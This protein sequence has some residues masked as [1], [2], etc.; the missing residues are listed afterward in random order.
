MGSVLQETIVCWKD[1]LP[2][3][4]CLY[5]FFY[6]FLSLN[7]LSPL[8]WPRRDVHRG[9]SSW[10]QA[11]HIPSSCGAGLSCQTKLEL[12]QLPARGASP[13]R[14]ASDTS[15]RGATTS[16]LKWMDAFLLLAALTSGSYKEIR[17]NYRGPLWVVIVRQIINCTFQLVKLQALS[18]V[19]PPKSKEKLADLKIYTPAVCG[20][21]DINI[22]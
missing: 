9:S 12:L 7:T 16:A 14:D 13:P 15:R 11:S 20:R 22:F 2:D 3:L 19:Q 21:N 18:S 6:S 17:A 4:C 10:P 5:R 1:V 8:L